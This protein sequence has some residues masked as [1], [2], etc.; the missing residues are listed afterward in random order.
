MKSLVV[1]NTL[2]RKKEVFEPLNPPFVGLYVC[3]PTVYGDPHLGH[4]RSALT[5]DIVFRYM[6]HLGF[7][8]RYVRNITDV[9]H[10]VGDADEGESKVE[11][12][13]RL[14]KLEPMEVA[15]HYFNNYI[16]CMNALNIL[17]PSI[18]PRA[19]G[20]IIEQI[21]AVQKIIENGYAYETNGS[22]YFDVVKYDKDFGY[23]EL[24]GR[25]LEN[26]M[27]GSRADLEGGSEK[28]HPADF[29]LWKKA[30]PMHIMRW[31]SPWGEGFPGW[32]LE[33]TVMSTKYLGTKYDIHGGGMDL[34]FPHH[35]AEVAQSNACNC[36]APKE[37]H[38]EAK[39]W[40]H[41][42]MITLN[43]QKMGKSLGNAIDLYQFF[44]GDHPLLDKAYTAMNIRF[45]MLQAH[46]RST[47]DFS[48]E[49]LMASEKGLKRIT[50]GLARLDEISHEGRPVAVNPDFE[51]NL[52]SFMNDCEQQL[53]DDFHTAKTIARIF[54]V[55]PVINQLHAKK[56]GPFTVNPETFE[57]FKKD[58]HTLFSDILGLQMEADAGNAGQQ[59]ETM[60]GLM[61]LI[62]EL[63]ATARQE[64]NWGVS[65]KIR[66]K[67]NELNI[68]VKDTPEGMEWK[69]G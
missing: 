61:A 24:S 68:E 10:L 27:A 23:G 48:N 51:E 39:Y 5:F 26:M 7:K 41:N 69:I 28:R 33:C 19:T 42:N 40:L 53:N 60:D 13:A 3:G 67:L 62:G 22:V 21:E 20:H 8:V 14:E 15:Q 55:L 59:N 9:G 46:Y 56:S 57:K 32:H 34:I 37:L 30:D 11:K 2:S 17:R 64:K 50:E 54:E 65:D 18:E 45:F 58:F 35:E 16:E 29:A 1:Y 44:S 63:R 6:K 49:A 38:G 66:D 4:A 12:K 36:N 47:L 43:G 25:D 52:A 31:N